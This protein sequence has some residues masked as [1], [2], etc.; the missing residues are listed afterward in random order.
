M[1]EINCPQCGRM[2]PEEGLFCPQCGAAQVPQYSRTQLYA[3]LHRER[4]DRTLLI[5]ALGLLGGIAAGVGIIFGL[6]SAGML[7]PAGMPRYQA[8][9]NTVAL[10]A[11]A[12]SLGSVIVRLIL[13]R[14]RRGQRKAEPPRTSSWRDGLS[15]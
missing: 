15:L 8:M 6:D 5:G 2:Y 1:P 3:A 14:R 10:A 13:R 9:G 12:G 4:Q 11:F 7:P